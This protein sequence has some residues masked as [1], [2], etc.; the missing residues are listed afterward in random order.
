MHTTDVNADIAFVRAILSVLRGTHR[1]PT[2]K[3]R[4]CQKNGIE[5]QQPS[6]PDAAIVL[7]RV[8]RRRISGMVLPPLLIV[9]QQFCHEGMRWFEVPR[10]FDF[11]DEFAHSLRY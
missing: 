9:F 3:M 1:R 8:P 4:G 6:S 11:T 5:D 2:A 7:G 10:A